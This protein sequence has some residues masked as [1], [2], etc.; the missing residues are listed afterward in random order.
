[1]YI[2]I[3]NRIETPA[4]EERRPY[5]RSRM[6]FKGSIIAE[7]SCVHHFCVANANITAGVIYPAVV[8]KIYYGYIL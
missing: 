1:M 2:V 5:N 8:R 3:S 7:L 6:Y 4:E